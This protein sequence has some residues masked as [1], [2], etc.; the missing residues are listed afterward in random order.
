MPAA[1]TTPDW[2]RLAMI[3]LAAAILVVAILRVPVVG[4]LVRALAAT[5][6]LAA[7]IW[8]LLRQAPFDPTLARLARAAGL[9]TQSVEGRTLRIAMARDGHFWLDARINGVSRRMLVDSGATIT[10]LSKDSA[11]AAG[12]E[13][14]PLLLPVYLRTA[15]GTVRAATGTIARFEAGPLVA[16]NLKI[17][18]A[19]TLGNVDILGMNFLSELASWRVEGRTLILVPRS[20][21][22]A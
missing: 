22:S 7:A 16:E 2:L 21:G 15:N 12:I 11:R 4:A 20:G 13:D 17:I 1:E 19:P 18:I 3:A 8:L 5:A 9:S 14:D 10:A 6:M